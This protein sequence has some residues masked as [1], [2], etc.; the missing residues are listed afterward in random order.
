MPLSPRASTLEL[1][2]APALNSHEHEGKCEKDVVI[3]FEQNRNGLLRYVVS[4]GL[5]VHD[6]E[7]II[8]E[9]FLS[10]FQHLRRGRSRSNLRGWAFRVAHNLALK[11]CAEG[12]TLRDSSKSEAVCVQQLL[13]PYPNPEEQLARSRR[14]QRLLAVVSVLPEQDQPCLRLRAEGMRY[15]EISAILGMSLGAVSNSLARSLARLERA[16]QR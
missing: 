5:P 8:Q 7:E 15:R 9:V 13:D 11:R 14:Q 4:L 6:G 12:R 16:D 3:L 2:I 10:L 1:C